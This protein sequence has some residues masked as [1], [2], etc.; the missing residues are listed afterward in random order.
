MTS[1][2]TKMSR[3]QLLFREMVLGTLVY[4]LVLGFFADYTDTLI[5]GTQS[6]I[7]AAAIVLEILTLLTFELKNIVVARIK[8]RRFKYYLPI[9]Y[10]S[11]WL[12]M[13]FS[14]FVFLWVIDII[15]GTAVEIRGFVA[16]LLMIITMTLVKLAIDKFYQKLAD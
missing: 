5:I 7:F 3:K 1:V 13:F 10:F 2:T 8:D 6:T 12:I 11:V 15:F 16:L 9:K 14:K 4:S